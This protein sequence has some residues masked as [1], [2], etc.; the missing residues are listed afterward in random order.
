VGGLSE[1]LHVT[2]VCTV[3]FGVV[4]F[5]P[6][7][8][9]LSAGLRRH[10]LLW[11][12]PVGAMVLVLELT[13]LS[14][15]Y[16][17][18]DIALAIVL[19]GA[20]ALGIYAWRRDPGL[21]AARSAPEGADSWR[22]L[23][24]PLYVALL[25]GAVALIPMFRGGNAT[26]IG[27]GSDAHLAVGSAK[28]LQEHHPTAVDPAEPV[29]QIPLTWRSKP[30]IYLGFAAVARLS[31]LEPYAVIATLS[32]ALLALA[33]L[34]WYLLARVM[35][36]AGPW[37]AGI[38]LGVLGLN[39]IA[40][41]TGMHPY[42]NQTW[43]YVALPFSILLSWHVVRHRTRGVVA[44]Y[45][46]F[47]ALLAFAYPLALPIPL[48]SAA[49]FRG[50]E[51]R[52][53]GLPVMRRPRRPSR[54]RLRWMVPLGLL[55]FFPLLGIFE[56]LFASFDLLLYRKSLANWGGDLT[57]YFAEGW[58]FGVDTAPSAPI[59]L[60]ALIAGIVI[61]LRRAPRDIRSGLGA[62]IAFGIAGALYFRT[63]DYGWYFH[64]KT[65][66]FVAPIAVAVGVIGL[67]RLRHRWM[68]IV[69]MLFVLV[70]ARDS[71]SHEIAI[72]FDQL[73]PQLLELKQVDAAL[74]PGASL[75]LDMNP[76]GRM[77]W[78]GYML[79]GQRLCS[80]R[81]VLDTDYPH[82]AI[83]RAADYVL[84]DRD[85]RK[86]SDATG[87]IVK[88]IQSYDVYRLRPNLAGGDRC[89]QR[90]VQTVTEK[91]FGR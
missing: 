23:L 36:G 87:P 82:V 13:V 47:L 88:R 53:R 75:R 20:S 25:I 61:A 37:T 9:L 21:P 59:V 7:R 28:F 73:S 48:L 46:G 50:C 89:S 90:M 62:V 55:L 29:D 51:R 80:Q 76:D 78:A 64:F 14:Y 77:L 41:H 6:T 60:L 3:L 86:P 40:L 58:F 65:L 57:G 5:G 30:P 67:S 74:P 27:N 8:L 54:R 44:L 52:R 32:A 72:T 43:G 19:T 42:F 84:V 34:G 10:E 12:A 31:G 15:A 69:A 38:V 33:A 45:G 22:M 70:V 63:L 11:V 68:A 18:F 56:K 85:L 81:P 35:F 91:T 26:V 79:S 39:R 71:A 4:G 17:P 66:A 2:A 24:V 83:S 1:A 49:V 16:V